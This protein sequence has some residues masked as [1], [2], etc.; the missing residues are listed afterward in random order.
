MTESNKKSTGAAD[1]QDPAAAPLTAYNRW[2]LGVLLLNLLPFAMAI[3]YFIG[4]IPLGQGAGSPYLLGLL[5]LAALVQ[6]INICLWFKIRKDD[7]R[8]MFLVVCAIL[9]LVPVFLAVNA[10][11]AA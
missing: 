8:R 3:A 4:A 6:C 7:A 1:G 2:R 11:G 5:G 10:G 9:G